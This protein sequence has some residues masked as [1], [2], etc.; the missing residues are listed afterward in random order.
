[1]PRITF[2]CSTMAV[3]KDNFLAKFQKWLA[4]EGLYSPIS[5]DGKAASSIA[6]AIDHGR[7]ERGL[8]LPKLPGRIGIPFYLRTQDGASG[9]DSEQNGQLS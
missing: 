5:L 3:E 9:N 1:M 6:K 8:L 2:F 4:D 7:I